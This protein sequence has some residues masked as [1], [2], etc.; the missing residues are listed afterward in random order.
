MGDDIRKLAKRFG[1]KMRST[2]DRKKFW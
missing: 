2:V 1:L